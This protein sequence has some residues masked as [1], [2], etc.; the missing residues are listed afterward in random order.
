MPQSGAVPRFA[1][2]PYRG[3]LM[4]GYWMNETS[5]ILRPVIEAYYCNPDFSPAEC[6]IMVAYLRQWMAGFPPLGTGDLI[7]R[8]DTLTDRRAIGR[9]LDDARDLGID[10]L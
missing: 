7:P 9:W 8:L 1:A 3:P 6:V 10:P 2:R 4:V 5:G